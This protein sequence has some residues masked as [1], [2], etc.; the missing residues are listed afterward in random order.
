MCRETAR[1]EELT[2]RFE[3]TFTFEHESPSIYTTLQVIQ[4]KIFSEIEMMEVVPV[5]NVHK[6]KM[7]VH[8]IL[9]CYNITQEENEEEDPRKVQIH[10][11]KI[12]QVVEGP[13]LAS[14]AYTQPIKMHKVNIGMIENPKFAQIGDYWNDETI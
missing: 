13:D 12:A 7:T 9:E 4:M 6:A 2:R 1:W 14:V 5:C 3:I 11:T 10:E 8:K